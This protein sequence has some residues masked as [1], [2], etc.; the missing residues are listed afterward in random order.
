MAVSGIGKLTAKAAGAVGDV[1]G[2]RVYPETEYALAAHLFE[3][4]LQAEKDKGVQDR[5]YY[6]RLMQSCLAIIR[7]ASRPTPEPK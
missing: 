5:D 6:L 7:G 1:I 3:R 2:D 4:I